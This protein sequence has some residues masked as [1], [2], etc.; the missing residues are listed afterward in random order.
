MKHLLRT[1][2][3]CVSTGAIAWAVGAEMLPQDSAATQ[4]TTRQRAIE[5][6]VRIYQIKNG[7]ADEVQMILH[8]LRAIS[9][10]IVVD[11]RTNSLIINATPEEQE[12]VEE[13]IEELDV[14]SPEEEIFAERLVQ[15]YDVADL[16]TFVSLDRLV[17]LIAIERHERIAFEGNRMMIVSGDEATMDRV[18][19]LLSMF[20]E[21]QQANRPDAA[22]QR[23]LRVIWLVS[24]LDAET[25]KE[26]PNDLSEVVAELAAFGIDNLRLAA[27]S[28]IEIRADE[29]FEMSSIAQIT[30]QLSI[31]FEISGHADQTATGDSQLQLRIA[32]QSTN[33][34]LRSSVESSIVAPTGHSIVLAVTPMGDMQSVFVIQVHE[35]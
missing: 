5:S 1:I 18:E 9:G 23:R 8:D 2:T 27:Q 30:E 26:A 4:G 35:E 17:P 15:L 29:P 6:V 25:S 33:G 10:M 31:M 12:H 19:N 20:R 11:E 16:A 14:E 32:A 22:S 21:Q 24:G 7:I 3:V 28:I 34:A 13:L